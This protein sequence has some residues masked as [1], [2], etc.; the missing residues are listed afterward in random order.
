MGFRYSLN[1]KIKFVCPDCGQ[2]NRF[3]RYIDNTTGI[4]LS[5]YFGICDR[6]NGCG[7]NEK[8]IQEYIS[9]SENVNPTKIQS[10]YDSDVL[11]ETMTDYRDFKK[12]NRFFYQLEK[13]FGTEKTLEAINRYQLGTFYDGA[14]I[15]PY[16]FNNELKTAKIMWYGDDLHR[17]KE[18]PTKWLH[19]GSYTANDGKYYNWYNEDFNMC[20]PLFGWDLIRQDK[21]KTICLVEAE[22]TA[23]IMSIIYPE[24]IWVACGSIGYLQTYKF[25]ANNNRKWLFMPDM[26][27]HATTNQTVLDYWKSKVSKISESYT[28]DLCEF[29]D[30]VPKGI[31]PNI[32]KKMYDNGEDIADFMLE[33]LKFDRLKANSKDEI[34]SNIIDYNRNTTFGDCNYIEYMK[35]TLNIYV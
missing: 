18:K 9:D 23:V 34:F 30:Y 21:N 35:D 22:K 16:Y 3:V 7:F 27:F 17:D 25:I 2:A 13:V 26:G 29:V 15:Y 28:F 19:S 12:P 31:N 14:V 32:N 11:P 24:F 5:G 6:V 33:Y 4:Y 8:P 1:S 10:L 20:L